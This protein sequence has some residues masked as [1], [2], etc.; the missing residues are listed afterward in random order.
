MNPS[1]P[2]PAARCT[3]YISTD[4][5]TMCLW[6]WKALPYWLRRKMKKAQRAG[7]PDAV[8]GCMSLA[9]AVWSDPS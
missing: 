4:A 5:A 6:H 2:C 8:D 9:R 7:D 3:R 1:R